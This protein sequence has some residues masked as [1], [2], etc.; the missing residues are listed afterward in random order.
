MNSI[1]NNPVHILRGGRLLE[2]D[3]ARAM[4]IVLVVAGHWH[5]EDSPGWWN[6]IVGV[7]YTFH[8]PLFLAMSGYI[9]MITAGLRSYREFLGRKF[10]RLMVPYFTTSIIVLLIK[11]AM[12]GNLQV[13]H[14]VTLLSEPGS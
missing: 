7:I 12:Q 4:A 13:D 5:P 6:D 2:I 11:L 8:M 10:L 14:P 3:F 1:H 9:Y